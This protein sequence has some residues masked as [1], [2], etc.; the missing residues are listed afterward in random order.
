MFFVGRNNMSMYGDFSDL[1][2]EAE[3]LFKTLKTGSIALFRE[4]IDLY[5]V[6]DVAINSKSDVRLTIAVTGWNAKDLLVSIDDDVLIIN[7]GDI[8]NTIPLEGE[9]HT[10]QKRIKDVPFVKRIP[11]PKELDL[12]KAT[13]KHNNGTLVITIPISEK[14]VEKRKNLNIE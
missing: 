2:R 13:V 6:V 5:P 12:N 11:I 3:S 10:I 14:V 9:W 1:C 8:K 7:G 4:G